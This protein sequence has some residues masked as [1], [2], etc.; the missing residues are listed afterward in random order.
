MSVECDASRYRTGEGGAGDCYLL[1]A[2]AA[3]PFFRR[4]TSARYLKRMRHSS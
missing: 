3:S 4:M 2:M 1:A